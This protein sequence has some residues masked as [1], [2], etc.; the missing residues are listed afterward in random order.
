MSLRNV[1]ITYKESKGSNQQSGYLIKTIMTAR[2]SKC[3]IIPP[4]TKYP[5]FVALLGHDLFKLL[6]NSKIRFRTQKKK[7]RSR[8]YDRRL[9]SLV[10]AHA[11]GDGFG[12]QKRTLNFARKILYLPL[13]TFTILH[14]HK[15]REENILNLLDRVSFIKVFLDSCSLAKTNRFPFAF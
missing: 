14:E 1:R 4:S 15:I 2:G 10:A 9:N 5:K 8:A 13:T 7:K 3:K 6:G 11:E 12:P